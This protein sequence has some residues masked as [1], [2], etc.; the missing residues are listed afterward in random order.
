MQEQIAAALGGLVKTSS[1]A[2]APDVT[3]LRRL[4]RSDGLPVEVKTADGRT[5]HLVLRLRPRVGKDG[6]RPDWWDGAAEVRDV[7]KP[8]EAA[9]LWFDADGMQHSSVADSATVTAGVSAGA[10]G[11]FKLNGSGGVGRG[12]VGAS[13]SQGDGGSSLSSASNRSGVPSLRGSGSW[14]SFQIG[15]ELVLEDADRAMDDRNVA[16]LPVA[17]DVRLPVEMTRAADGAGPEANSLAAPGRRAEQQAAGLQPIQVTAGPEQRRDVWSARFMAAENAD[18][19]DLPQQALRVIA[20]LD[21]GSGTSTAGWLSPSSTLGAQFD[22]LVGEPHV[23]RYLRNVGSGITSAPVLLNDGRRLQLRLD[24]EVTEG[25][26]VALDTPPELHKIEATEKV[27]HTSTRNKAI[28]GTSTA[29]AT[30]AFGR[31]SEWQP[32][33]AP[34][35]KPG[36][37]TPPEGGSI[38]GPVLNGNVSTSGTSRYSETTTTYEKSKIIARGRMT[39]AVLPAT[40]R[41]TFLVD[42]MPH[43][44]PV[45]ADGSVTTRVMESDAGRLRE[46]LTAPLPAGAERPANGAGPSEAVTSSSEAATAGSETATSGSEATSSAAPAASVADETA[47]SADGRSGRDAPR[48]LREGTGLGGAHIDEMVGASSV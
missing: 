2:D 1:A 41:L 44:E 13:A 7:A 5:R 17:T 46:Q 37:E 14:R 4:A 43:G 36:Q 3:A 33:R 11:K 28:M 15:H 45:R 8:G 48:A 21:G 23:M 18:L 47:S 22:G 10:T 31:D 34:A 32:D 27:Q 9:W 40:W 25:A 24:A 42:G 16:S 6:A 26:D 12:L 29:E 30:G 20:D 19:G 35:G 39:R 38:V